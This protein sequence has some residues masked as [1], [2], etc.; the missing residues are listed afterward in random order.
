[1]ETGDR[2]AGSSEQGFRGS[3]V[4]SS[5]KIRSDPLTINEIS[6]RVKC[7][8]Q[9]HEEGEH[10]RRQGT[11]RRRDPDPHLRGRLGYRYI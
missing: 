5:R 11:L 10:E 7:V 2:R 9:T 4:R 1:M 6:L 8:C 3:E